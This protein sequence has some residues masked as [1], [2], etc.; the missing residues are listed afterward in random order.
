[1]KS[2]VRNAELTAS[3]N[4]DWS[5]ACVLSSLH[6]IV[7]YLFPVELDASH[8]VVGR[9][10]AGPTGRR[11]P[12]VD[13]ALQPVWALRCRSLGANV[14]PAQN[15]KG[16]KR[17]CTER[18]M[19]VQIDRFCQFGQRESQRLGTQ[20]MNKQEPVYSTQTR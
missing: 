4:E 1:M 10:I 13:K 14:F 7:C 20:T 6:G 5:I 15:L 9:P 8:C 2:S 12:R 18:L 17:I 16:L 11:E 3:Q 19:Y